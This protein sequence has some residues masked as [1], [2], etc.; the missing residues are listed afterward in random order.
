M[1]VCVCTFIFF[2]SSP[3]SGL[4]CLVCHEGLY[5]SFL[6][7]V[8]ARLLLKP[9]IIH[10][11]WVRGIPVFAWTNWNIMNER[12]SQAEDWWCKYGPML[13]A[14]T[15]QINKPNNVAG[16]KFAMAGTKLEPAIWEAL[17]LPVPNG[18]RGLL[19]L[20]YLTFP[21][22]LKKKA[23]ARKIIKPSMKIRISISKSKYLSLGSY[24]LMMKACRTISVHFFLSCAFLL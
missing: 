14:F 15:L 12:S 11:Y 24:S 3:L 18:T 10:S 2:F 20:V 8:F 19:W 9:L 22:K 7:L 4:V 16:Q 1:C 6:M 17:L 5:L 21:R 13:P 23:T